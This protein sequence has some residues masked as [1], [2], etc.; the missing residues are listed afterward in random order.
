MKLDDFYKFELVGIF[1]YQCKETNLKNRVE[2]VGRTE[3]SFYVLIGFE[4]KSDKEQVLIQFNNA[5]LP[6]DIEKMVSLNQDINGRLV[7]YY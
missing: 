7:C 4:L 6:E 1:E 3:A 5:F 2:Y